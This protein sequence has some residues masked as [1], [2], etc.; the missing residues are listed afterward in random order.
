MPL[1]GQTVSV[2][3]PCY[4]GQVLPIAHH[5]VAEGLA[6]L[7]IKTGHD[8]CRLV[9][10][11]Q[12]KLTTL[13]CVQGMKAR[14]SFWNLH[15]P[16]LRKI[17]GFDGITTNNVI[18]LLNNHNVENRG[19]KSYKKMVV[20]KLESILNKKSKPLAQTQVLV[21]N[22]SW[23]ISGCVLAS[24]FQETEMGNPEILRGENIEKQIQ[25]NNDFQTNVS[26]SGNDSKEPLLISL[27]S[28][29]LCGN[30]SDNFI[31]ARELLIPSGEDCSRTISSSN[32]VNDSHEVDSSQLVVSSGILLES[33]LSQ[34][35]IS[36]P[37]EIQSCKVN[38]AVT[39]NEVDI[40][41]TKND[42]ELDIYQ[43]FDN[44]VNSDKVETS[45]MEVQ[46][47]LSDLCQHIEDI[48]DVINSYMSSFYT[49]E[50]EHDNYPNVYTPQKEV[51]AY[52]VECLSKEN[53]SDQIVTGAF[54]EKEL[55]GVDQTDVLQNVV[56]N[57]IIYENEDETPSYCYWNETNLENDLVANIGVADLNKS[58]EVKTSAIV[59]TE[60]V[61]KTWTEFI[62]NVET[63]AVLE[64]LVNQNETTKSAH[65][66][67]NYMNGFWAN[68]Y[69]HCIFQE[70]EHVVYTLDSLL[71]NGIFPLDEANNAAYIPCKIV[72]L[73]DEE[74]FTVIEEEAYKQDGSDRS[75][76]KN[77]EHQAN[78]QDGLYDNVN[79]NAHDNLLMND[80][81]RLVDARKTADMSCRIVEFDEDKHF[82]VLEE[83]AQKQD[84]GLA[85]NNEHQANHQGGSYDCTNEN[86]HNLDSLLMNE[87][88]PLDEAKKAADLPYTF[89]E[90]DEERHFTVIEEKAQKQDNGLTRN[91]EHQANHQGGSYDCTNENP[92]NLDSLLMNGIYPLD[93]A[94]KAADL[95]CT[96]VEIDEERHFTVIEEKAQKQDNG[97]TRNNKH[98]ANH[99]G[100]SYDCTNE[101]PHNLDS[102]LINGIF[103]LNEAKNAAD[104][105]CRIVE[106]DE[107]RYFTILE[108]KVQNQDSSLIRNNNQA[109]HQD[110]IQGTNDKNGTITSDGTEAEETILGNKN[111]GMH[112]EPFFHQEKVNVNEV[113]S[114]R[115]PDYKVVLE[116]VNH[117]GKVDFLTQTVTEIKEKDKNETYYGIVR[118]EQP[119]QDCA[120]GQNISALDISYEKVNIQNT[121]NLDEENPVSG[122]SMFE[123]IKE[124]NNA[125]ISNSSFLFSSPTTELNLTNPNISRK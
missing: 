93:E 51:A 89:V 47:L 94:K 81:F 86:P 115:E 100:G 33:K 88:F 57:H 119:D 31:P 123:R 110:E 108:E 14:N 36:I 23:P 29:N 39:T 96:F 66:M 83:K 7:S 97:L 46:S 116:S 84:N 59:A 103:P 53:S 118:K 12:S 112:S 124:L 111:K 25:S 121:G 72:E 98:Q 80:I 18:E 71:K 22:V 37:S 13:N 58:E 20:S 49:Q 91:N 79:Y 74:D 92:H 21:P 102:P 3:Q 75:L 60:F 65:E 113:E 48:K 105:F 101:N 43:V 62:N 4:D 68:M 120:D 30:L 77:K 122:Y 69:D 24:I 78:R 76:T 40:L 11:S 106:F 87:I 63:H 55:S 2:I 41:V 70:A 10:D 1:K 90:I 6:L 56:E 15:K 19:L 44:V 99:Q 85:R 45:S 28:T 8:D 9:R 38:C 73:D 104:I 26:I 54:Y 35:Q 125:G 67:P 117:Q 114:S 52:F 5:V 61:E 42:H 82:T 27:H 109:N 50:E 64:D 16:E 107:E 34:H 17:K 95:P 32:P